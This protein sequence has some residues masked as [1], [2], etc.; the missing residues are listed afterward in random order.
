MVGDSSL[1]PRATTLKLKAGRS[2]EVDYRFSLPANPTPLDVFFL[3]DTSSSMDMSI[4]KLRDGM[5]RIVDALA[6]PK[7]D[8]QFGVGEIKDYP[9]PGFG[10]PTAGDF[11]YRL[12]RGDRSGRRLAGRRSSN[13]K[14]RAGPGGTTRSRS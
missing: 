9:I 5:Q 7:I 1:R 10:D 12:N 6:A 14:H 4:D 13:S 3:V 11:P 8:V 2:E